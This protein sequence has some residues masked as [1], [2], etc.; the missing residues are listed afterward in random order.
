MAI[1][2]VAADG[3][4]ATA[5]TTTYITNTRTTPRS[6]LASLYAQ[7][8]DIQRAIHRRLADAHRRLRL[9]DR[10]RLLW[11]LCSCALHLG[12]LQAASAAS[13]ERH[14]LIPIDNT[15]QW[16]S[17]DFLALCERLLRLVQGNLLQY[18]VFEKEEEE[19]GDEKAV[20]PA[21]LFAKSARYDPKASPALARAFAQ[22]RA[23][24]ADDGISMQSSAKIVCACAIA[25]GQLTHPESW[26]TWRSQRYHETVLS[27]MAWR[28]AS[29]GL[30]CFVRPILQSANAHPASNRVATTSAAERVF[31]RLPLQIAG[32]RLGPAEKLKVAALG[33]AAVYG[34]SEFVRAATTT[35]TTATAS[36]VDT[37]TVQLVL[38]QA[39]EA[40]FT[41]IM[42]ILLAGVPC[43]AA[44]LWPRTMAEAWQMRRHRIATKTRAN[45][46]DV[47]VQDR[48]GWNPVGLPVGLTIPAAADTVGTCDIDSMTLSEALARN[49]SAL[50][51]EY[52]Y[53]NKPLI[54]RGGMGAGTR[55]VRARLRRGRLLKDG[56][57]GAAT[58]SLSQIPYPE[59]FL[60]GFGSTCKRAC[61]AAW[62]GR[63]S[64]PTQ[65]PQHTYLCPAQRLRGTSSHPRWRGLRFSPAQRTT[66]AARSRS[67]SSI[68]GASEPE[69]L[70]TGTFL[71]S[72]RLPG[73]ASIGI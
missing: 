13:Q 68:L 34:W 5:T 41:S 55:G 58:V 59:L 44:S 23:A 60:F 53:G 67:A 1:A 33:T 19:A 57:L 71:R 64:P 56:I 45:A 35:T 38:K 12:D 10:E 72:M 39:S 4:T 61:L 51:Q 17:S 63:P 73:A 46:D 28:A 37:R 25:S 24:I 52:V 47:A 48:G 31:T 11:L 3:G 9:A 36:C 43:T 15:A 7:L 29:T 70:R 18:L 26:P 6:E 21:T 2:T 16:T 65:A 50:L 49:P 32:G 69:H 62:G 54:V 40:V 22:A 66:F 27:G 8:P 14:R 42:P 30:A 20:H